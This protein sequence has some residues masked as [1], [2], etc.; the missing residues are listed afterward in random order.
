L[1]SGLPINS[2]INAA[3]VTYI[4]DG[5]RQNLG[6]TTAKGMDIA[7]NNAWSLGTGE[8]STGV[9]ATYFTD[10][11]TAAAPG[12]AQVDVLNT[13][14]F[15]Q[16]LRARGELG[17]RS[18]SLSALAFLNYTNSYDQAGVT[19]VREIDSFTTVDL[20]HP[21]STGQEATIPSRR[22]PWVV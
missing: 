13:I 3:L 10:L 16:R 19:P 5:R 2:P 1:G 17:W 9:N 7:I 12:A 18:G 20:I 14:N 22:A 6:Q 11:T 8:L 21:S 4:Q 15:P